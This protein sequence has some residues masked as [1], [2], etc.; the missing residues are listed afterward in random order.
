[1]K[2]IEQHLP[3]QHNMWE[4]YEL[5]FLPYNDENVRKPIT[6]NKQLINQSLTLTSFRV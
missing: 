2:D 6:G 3:S 1:M 4:A 5:R